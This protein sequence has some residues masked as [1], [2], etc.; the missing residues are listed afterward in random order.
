[1]TPIFVP[2]ATRCGR[3]TGSA[4]DERIAVVEDGFRTAVVCPFV[5]FTMITVQ[6]AL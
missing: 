2:R 1:M 5:V 4:W 6:R 3:V